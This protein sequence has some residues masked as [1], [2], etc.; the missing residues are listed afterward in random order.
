[1]AE[2]TKAINPKWRRGVKNSLESTE[3][4][5]G[6]ILITTDSGELFVDIDGKRIHITDIIF[7]TKSAVDGKS[8]PVNKF[9][10][11][12]DTME[13][14]KYDFTEKAYKKICTLKVADSTKAEAFGTSEN[15]VTERDVYYGLPKINN[16]KEYS[17]NNGIFAPSGSGST[18]EI[19]LSGGTNKEPVWVAA[20]KLLAKLG[21]GY[22]TCDTAANT[23]AKE[24]TLADYELVIGGHISV[25][26]TN[27]VPGNS[28]MN[29]N[30][31][32]AKPIQISGVAVSNSV[33]NAG[34][35]VAFVYDGSAYQALSISR[36]INAII[37]DDP[38]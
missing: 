37:K 18:D 33:I 4:K 29:V 34:D 27:D 25:K 7:T 2:E 10:L 8:V 21:S 11:T 1:M 35:V 17:A 20:Q 24:V 16:S 26:F 15:L 13:L 6:N 22:G 28:T 23:A 9:C 32:G 38:S 30:K 12:E 36:D 3:I 19:L 14:Y 31:K 5:D